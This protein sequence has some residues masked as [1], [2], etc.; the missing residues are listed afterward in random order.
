MGPW[1]I[2]RRYHDL[3]QSKQKRESCYPWRLEFIWKQATALATSNYFSGQK[4]NIFFPIGPHWPLLSCTFWP[5][6]SVLTRYRDASTSIHL[7]T[8]FLNPSDIPF[9]F[10]WEQFLGSLMQTLGSNEQRSQYHRSVILVLPHPFDSPLLC[11]WTCSSLFIYPLCCLVYPY[12][13]SH[14]VEPGRPKQ[15]PQACCGPSCPTHV[16]ALTIPLPQAMPTST[17]QASPG[18]R[19]IPQFPS[20]HNLLRG[21]CKGQTPKLYHKAV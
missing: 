1:K 21:L 3:Q 12:I 18:C 17:P 13:R 5:S 14:P 9:P 19:T 15:I 20:K 16:L 6:V 2:K 8:V 11:S 7:Y 10:F 4:K